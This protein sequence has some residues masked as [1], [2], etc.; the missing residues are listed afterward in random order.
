ME[1]TTKYDI[2]TVLWTIDDNRVASFKVT[3]I[4]VDVERTD[5]THNTMT[6]KYWGDMLED[7]HSECECFG[8]KT[9][10]LASLI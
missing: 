3:G 1:I 2:G 5:D 8:S 4:T 7:S 10:L 6:I 9:G